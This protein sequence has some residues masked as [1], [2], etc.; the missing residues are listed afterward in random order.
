MLH[1]CKEDKYKNAVKN[2]QYSERTYFNVVLKMAFTLLNLQIWFYI[3]MFGGHTSHFVNF[4]IYKMNF[5]IQ[6]RLPSEFYKTRYFPWQ[7][8][9]IKGKGLRILLICIHVK[10]AHKSGL[11][12]KFCGFFIHIFSRVYLIYTI[13]LFVRHTMRD[14]V[15]GKSLRVKIF[16]LNWTC[17]EIV[18]FK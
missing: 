5:K 12:E 11:N 18:M 3:F 6:I 10:K 2:L 15:Y 8:N 7:Y 17:F 4:T 16:H 9:I 1:W 14:A 13:Y